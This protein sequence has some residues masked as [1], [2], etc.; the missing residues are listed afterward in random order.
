MIITDLECTVE[1]KASEEQGAIS[2]STCHH[3][4][5]AQNID[6]QCESPQ[7][8]EGEPWE[9]Q[10]S[11]NKISILEEWIPC[12]ETRDQRDSKIV[13]NISAAASFI[14]AADERVVTPQT[15]VGTTS[16]VESNQRF[17]EAVQGVTPG[18]H[19]S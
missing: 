5:T 9:A 3:P 16:G 11:T 18:V 2:I 4:S 12:D 14:R 10:L 17:R 6:N 13:T 1:N 19:S 7:A 8:S 15:E